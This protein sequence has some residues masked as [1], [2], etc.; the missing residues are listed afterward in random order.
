MEFMN[1]VLIDLAGS[2]WVY[3]VAVLVC[4]IDGFFPPVPSESV[5]VALGA[6]ALSTG[7]VHLAGLLAVAATG[8]FVGDNIAYLVGR[9]IRAERVGWMRRPRVVAA[10]G[11]ARARLESHG[12]FVIFTAR[13]IP[14]GRVA[15]NM[16]AGATGYPWR[17][18]AAIDA[19]AAVT[20]A[21][22]SVFIGVAVGHVLGDQPLLAVIVA[23]VLAAVLGLAVD[24]TLRTIARGR[25]ARVTDRSGIT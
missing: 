3:L 20:W 11:W 9:T 21:L 12:A 1:D 8:A 15:V 19:A 17:R 23:V 13:Y 2:P 6:L 7:E 24:T 25:A 4:I 16:T 22:Y 5:I 18:F 10:S 14:V